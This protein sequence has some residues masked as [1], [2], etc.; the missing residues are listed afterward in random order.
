VEVI[1]VLKVIDDGSLISEKEMKKKFADHFICYFVINCDDD[2]DDDCFVKVMAISEN[3]D[4]LLEYSD[5]LE[6][7]IDWDNTEVVMIGVSYGENIK[8]SAEFIRSL[9]E[10]NLF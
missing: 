3:E 2:G 1:A 6:S 10:M 7:G 4:E 9:P 8:R 5:K